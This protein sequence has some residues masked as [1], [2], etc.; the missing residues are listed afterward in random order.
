[1]KKLLIIG[2]TFLIFQIIVLAIEIDIGSPAINRAAYYSSRTVVNRN[3]PANLSGTITSIEIW[4]ATNMSNCEIATFYVVNE[5]NLSTRDTHPIGSVT[6]GS[7]Q[8]FSGLSLSV[9][10]GDYIGIYYSAGRLE[11]DFSGVGCWYYSAD[12]IPCSDA[13]FYYE[14]TKIVSLYGTGVAVEEEGN[15]IFFGCSF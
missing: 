5:D 9:Q 3:N 14:T 2:L 4:A 10:A 11:K 6:A 12:Y 8:T 13:L 7:K 1:M 15:A